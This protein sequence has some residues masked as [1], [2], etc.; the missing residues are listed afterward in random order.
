MHIKKIRIGNFKS[1]KQSQVIDLSSPLITLIGK[2][3]SGKT[4]VLDALFTLFDSRSANE[5]MEMDFRFYLELS[6]EDLNSFKGVFKIE[7]TDR[8]IE[9]YSTSD[10]HGLGI[11]INRIKST[12]LNELMS[13]TEESIFSLSKELKKEMNSYKILI[14]DLAEDSYDCEKLTIDVDFSVEDI[15]NSSNYGHIFSSFS[16]ELDN[17]VKKVSEII[18]ERRKGDE[19]ILSFQYLSNQFYLYRYG[20]FKLRYTRPKLTK[21]EQKHIIINE[22]AIKEEIDKINKKSAKQIAIIKNLY[23]RLKNKLETLSSLIEERYRFDDKEDNNFDRVLSRIISICNPKIYYLRNENSQLFFRNDL[24]WN[25]YYHS[26]DERTILENFIKYKY[27]TLEFNDINSK[28]ENKK[29]TADEIQKLSVD[30]ETFINENLPSFERNMIHRIKVSDDLT[31]SIVEKTGDEIPFSLTNSGRRWF[32]T[33]FFVKGCLQPGD[34]LIMDEP[35]NN[36]HPEAQVFIRKDIEEISK[37]NKI[38]ITTHSPYMISPNSYVYYIDMREDGTNLMSMDNIGMHHM[39]RNLGIFERETIIGDILINNELLSFES[40]GQRI[41]DLLKENGIRQKDVA[42]KLQIDDRELRRK[43]KGEHL[44]F[45][46]VEW[47]C[48][49]CGFNPIRLLLKKQV[50]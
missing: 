4:N 30:L 43:L 40:I 16:Q 32:Y 7:E 37:K 42:E 28:L 27:K 35:A 22:E 12:L 2:N 44:T 49:N 17:L 41:K 25:S 9:A 15:T 45:H 1:L 6:N 13:S 24:R 11:N 48:K 26:V 14:R 21:F 31:F 10:K 5:R 36:L 47:F 23:D 3:G 29:I 50:K 33:Y 46:D 19:L 39:A 20:D 18:G 34:I 38:I 8:I